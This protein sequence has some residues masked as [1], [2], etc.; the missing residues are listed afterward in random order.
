MFSARGSVYATVIPLHQQKASMSGEKNIGT[1]T[2]RRS[3]GPNRA[4]QSQKISDLVNFFQPEDEIDHTDNRLA[5]S[6]SD[7]YCGQSKNSDA[8]QRPREKDEMQSKIKRGSS[9]YGLGKSDAVNLQRALQDAEDEFKL[10]DD[11]LD[12]LDEDEFHSSES[13]PEKPKGKAGKKKKSKAVKGDN[14]ILAVKGTRKS[15]MVFT[16]DNDGHLTIGGDQ[17]KTKKKK[18]KTKKKAAAVEEELIESESYGS[19]SD[20]EISGM[21]FAKGGVAGTGGSVI[22]SAKSSDDLSH[23]GKED[24]KISS[25]AP[26]AEERKGPTERKTSIVKQPVQ[27]ASPRAAV[28]QDSKTF[29]SSPRGPPPGRGRGRGGTIGRGRG[30]AIARGRGSTIAGRGGATRRPEHGSPAARPSVANRGK[31]PFAPPP[32]STPAPAGGAMKKGELKDMLLELLQE[33]PE[34]RK[35]VRHVLKIPKPP[36]KK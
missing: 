7:R 12:L 6:N 29:V 22:Q 30:K 1:G 16:N 34:F 25:Q 26:S 13:E 35:K 24:D 19:D 23:I 5:R 10:M 4:R 17:V 21:S 15:G 31:G 32:S 9:S 2:G 28:R 3:L 11:D 18:K 20:D 36:R 27:A 33:D 14:D 8:I